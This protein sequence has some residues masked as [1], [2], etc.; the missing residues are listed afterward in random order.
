MLE[1]ILGESPYQSPTDMG[2]NMAGFAI[3]DDD[4]VS[5]A[6]R[7]EIVRRYFKN[8][9]EVTRTGAGEDQV[10]K[11]MVLMRKADVDVDLSPARQAALDKAEESGDLSGALELPD[12]RVITGRTSKLL[13]ASASVLLNAMKAQADIPDD[14]YIISDE[15]MAPICRLRTD[16]LGHVSPQLHPGEML[17]ALSTSSLT[18][19]MAGRALEH[20][21]ELNNCDTYFSAIITSDDEQLYK[22][23]GINVCCEP[24]YSSQARYQK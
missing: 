5:D 4:A 9:E 20:L 15:A 21:R 17:I 16:L 23:L 22:S 8:A 11:L 6:A 14:M 3:F 24:R 13:S 18:N 7:N 2:V 19:P 1:H 12:G 10:K